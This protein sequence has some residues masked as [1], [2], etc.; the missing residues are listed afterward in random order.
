MPEF[1]GT[2]FARGGDGARVVGVGGDVGEVVPDF[3]PALVGDGFCEEGA[4]MLNGGVGFASGAAAFAAVLSCHG[5]P[6]TRELRPRGCS[7]GGF[8]LGGFLSGVV[9]RSGLINQDVFKSEK[10]LGVRSAEGTGI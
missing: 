5:V 3:L 4:G 2:E 6:R 10:C 8:G 7:W 1:D 9:L